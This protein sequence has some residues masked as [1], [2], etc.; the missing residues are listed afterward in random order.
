MTAG[1]NSDDR[2]KM[3]N[4]IESIQKYVGAPDRVGSF[5]SFSPT[6]HDGPSGT[7]VVMRAIRGG[8]FVTLEKQ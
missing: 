5:A 2:A 7:F 6:K 4:G 8:T 3:R 1:S